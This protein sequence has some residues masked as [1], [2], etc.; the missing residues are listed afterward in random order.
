M[1]AGHRSGGMGLGKGVLMRSRELHELTLD[2]F[3]RLY[4]ITACV[5]LYWCIWILCSTEAF[6]GFYYLSFFSCFFTLVLYI[7]GVPSQCCLLLHVR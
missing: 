1:S 6:C 2:V 4:Y 7:I 5:W 3:V